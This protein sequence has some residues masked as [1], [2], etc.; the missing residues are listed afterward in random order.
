MFSDDILSTIGDVIVFGSQA[1]EII[2]LLMGDSR[3]GWP[4]SRVRGQSPA[5]GSAG[6]KKHLT[7]Q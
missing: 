3:N 5:D 2:E 1:K 4:D 6:I 7:Y